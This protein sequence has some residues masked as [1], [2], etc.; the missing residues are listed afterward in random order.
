MKGSSMLN[1]PITV[2]AIIT[3]KPFQNNNLKTK[4]VADFNYP[5]I[6]DLQKQIE[7]LENQQEIILQFVQKKNTH[8]WNRIFLWFKRRTP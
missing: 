1:E 2:R 5:E 8:F 4:E 7:R 3:S 6:L